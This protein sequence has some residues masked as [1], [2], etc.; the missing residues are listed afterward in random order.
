MPRPAAALTRALPLLA[1]LGGCTMGPNFHAPGWASPASWF[2]GK[3]APGASV[4]SQPVVAPVRADWWALFGDPILTKLES[5]VAADNLD[6]RSATERLVESRD[7]LGIAGAARYPVFNAN[8][9]YQRQKAS[10]VG[11]L[12]PIGQLA[13]GGSGGFATVAGG[14][15]TPVDFQP[16]D[17]YQAGFDAVWEPDLWGKVRREMESAGAQLHA[18]AEARRG[19]LL[20]ALAEVARDY[21]ALRGTQ[22]QLRIARENLRTARDGLKL[23]QDR[24]A[25]GVTT[26]LDVANA[27]AQLSLTAAEIPTLEQRER[28]EM[29]AL[30]LLLGRPPGALAAMLAVPRPV[31]PVPPRIPV[32]FPSELLLRRPDIR[33]AVQ[34]LHAATADIGAAEADFYPSVTLSASFGFQALQ[35]GNLWKWNARQYD[36]GPGITIPIFQGGMLKYR[37][38]LTEAKQRE[39]AIAY[40][41]TVLT[42]WHEVDNALTAYRDEQLRRAQLVDA[43]AANRKALALARSRY[44]E[45]VEDFLTVLTAERGLLSAEQQLA[46][47]TTTVSTNLVGLYKVL[48]GGWERTYPPRPVMASESVAVRT[49]ASGH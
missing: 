49:T 4:P 38:K 37:L 8:G 19:V 5:Q 6:V 14:P 36:V 18:S 33:Q 23:T 13:A 30:A 28:E 24:A 46:Q 17:V 47:S 20:T 45:G 32:G 21:I 44:Q 11:Q 41:R 1:L 29:N 2:A 31:P 42:A 7:Q 22:E 39:A 10:N 35:F 16:F 26:D 12:S 3:P 25:A 15:K 34:T 9:S 40:T 27:S 48:G 43:V